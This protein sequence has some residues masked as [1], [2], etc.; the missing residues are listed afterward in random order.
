MTAL[1]PA[2][3]LRAATA[4]LRAW[5]ETEPDQSFGTSAISAF[6]PALASWLEEEAHR[7]EG[8]VTAAHN[9]FHD[10]PAARDAFLTT[11]PGKP[12]DHALAVARQILGTQDTR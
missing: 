11:G 3:V 7:Y 10:D 5:I 9:V 12:S 1:T 6:G 8:A 4:T 2:D